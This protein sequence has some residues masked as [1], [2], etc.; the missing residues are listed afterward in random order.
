MCKRKWDANFT[1]SLFNLE[2]IS[3]SFQGWNSG[4]NT[5]ISKYCCKTVLF[6]LNKIPDLS[7]VL[8]YATVIFQSFTADLQNATALDLFAICV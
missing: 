1:I 2:T 5:A 6:C 8:M 3:K 4:W 7:S